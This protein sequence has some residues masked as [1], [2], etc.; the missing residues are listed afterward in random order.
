M[1]IFLILLLIKP[2]GAN[3]IEGTETY[4]DYLFILV[5]GIK[6]DSGVFTGQ[7]DLGDLKNYLENNLDLTGRVFCYNFKDINGSNRAAAEEFGNRFY[8]NDAPGMNAKCWLDKAKDDFFNDKRN[9]G[10]P[11]PSKFIVITHSMGNMAVRSY[12]YSEKV[13]G[14]GKGFYN[15]DIAKVVFIAPPF[16]DQTW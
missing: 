1:L 9:A 4:K 10:K 13:F 14:A 16:W 8:N 3:N 7:R 11:L 12:I 15:D 5:H 2:C 6:A